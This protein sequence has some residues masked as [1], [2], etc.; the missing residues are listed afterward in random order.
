MVDEK[1]QHL[2]QQVTVP[3]IGLIVV[4]A[5]LESAL[6]CCI[7]EFDQIECRCRSCVFVSRTGATP[8]MCTGLGRQAQ[9]GRVTCTAELGVTLLMAR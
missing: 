2:L 7:L 4:R 5:L 3:G 6:F 1:D 8:P 9:G